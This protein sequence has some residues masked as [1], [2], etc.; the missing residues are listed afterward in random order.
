VALLQPS[1]PIIVR[2]VGPTSD[3]L[4][5]GE[6]ILGALGLTGAIALAALILGILLGGVFI[7]V[8]IR[9][10]RNAFNGETSDE[11]SMHLT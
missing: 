11:L 6:V 7:L 3:E 4:G 10:P 9:H 1:S 2:V 8:R 5:L